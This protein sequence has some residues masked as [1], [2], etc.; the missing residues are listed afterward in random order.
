VPAVLGVAK[1]IR[2][3]GIAV[4]IEQ[5]L[6]GRDVVTAILHECGTRAER[7]LDV[8]VALTLRIHDSRVAAITG[9][10]SDVDA[11]DSYFDDSPHADRGVP[12]ADV[13]ALDPQHQRH[14][15]NGAEKVA[16]SSASTGLCAALMRRPGFDE[17]GALQATRLEHSWGRQTGR[18]V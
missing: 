9:Y 1:T 15:P 11:Y 18:R 16:M 10:I 3:H 14:G 8:R 12:S 5:I 13:T 4:E 6:A 7:T 17:V 2:Q